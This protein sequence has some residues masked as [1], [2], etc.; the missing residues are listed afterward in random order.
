MSTNRNRAGYDRPPVTN[1]AQPNEKNKIWLF[2]TYQTGGEHVGSSQPIGKR[3]IWPSGTD[4]TVGEHGGGGPVAPTPVW[5]YFTRPQL[6]LKG[7]NKHEILVAVIFTQ[8]RPEWVGDFGTRPKNSLSLWLRT[9]IYLLIGEIFLTLSST[10]LKNIKW[11]FSSQNHKLNEFDLCKNPGDE[12]LM[13]N[14]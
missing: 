11:R 12:Y 8:I 4:Q 13:L 2:S 10:A 3:R 7:P 5:K 14:A 9:Y 1:H 6:P